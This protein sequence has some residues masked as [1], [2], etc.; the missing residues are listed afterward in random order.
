MKLNLIALLTLLQLFS[1]N[2]LA[3]N[4]K[5]TPAIDK[6]IVGGEEA[7]QNAWPWIAALVYTYDEVTTDVESNG[8]AFDSTS[9]TG[10]PA[11]SASGLLMDCGIGDSECAA[12]GQICLIERGD[13]NF[14]EKALNCEAGGGV[15]VIIYN[16]EDGVISGTLGDDFNGAIPVVAVTQEDGQSLIGNVGTTTRIEVASNS[17]LVQASTCGGSFLGDRWVLTASHCVE[18]PNVMSMKVNIGEYD[19]SDGAENAIAIKNIYK[20][21]DYDNVTLVNDIALIELV[22]SVDA[23]SISLASLSTTN[24]AVFSQQMATVIGWGGREGYAAGEGPTSDFPDV[25]HQVDLTL[26]ENQECANM[27]AEAQGITQSVTPHE[28]GVET[29]MVCAGTYTGGR[30]SCQGDS[31]G[32][33]VLETNEGYQQIGVV[34]W[35]IGCAAQ[36]YPGVYARVAEFLPWVEAITSGV[37][38]QPN[39]TLGYLPTSM[40]L[41]TTIS[42]ANNSAV[43]ASLTLAIDNS[44]YTIDAE[45]CQNLAAGD[46]CQATVTFNASK[47][48]AYDG[49]INVSTDAPDVTGT[50]TKVTAFAVNSSDA[51]ATEFSSNTNV[52]WYSGG[53]TSWTDNPVDDGVQSGTIGNLELSV[54]L[55]QV[56]GAGTLSFE[57]SVSSEENVDDPDSPFDALYLYVNGELFNFISGEVDFEVVE[58]ELAEGTNHIAWVYEKDPYAEDYDD[59][60][61]IKSVEFSGGEVGTPSTPVVTT[62]TNDNAR[63]SSG[64][65]SFG[66]HLLL[67]IPL[68][69]AVRRSRK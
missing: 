13:I 47:Q 35:G 60:G 20:H 21:S 41:S 33:L 8:S 9:F 26:F 4:D 48:G 67:L 14:S 2:V 46:S 36:G 28:M 55:A 64:G 56:E 40:P 12:S 16:N 38:M 44:A 61:Y 30:G 19:L 25:L 24:V 43:T 15:G 66:G 54:L 65:S 69:L 18:D 1:A 49:Y 50:Q 58:L 22:Q 57:W 39:L 6:R 68:L 59:T 29:V 5:Y 37:A 53:D 3:A 34:S 32:P 45:D 31:G 51:V 11:G 27:M 63:S 23:P 17:K 10:S 42:A 7:E 62:P 52:S